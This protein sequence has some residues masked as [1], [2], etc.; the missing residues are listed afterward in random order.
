MDSAFG[1]RSHLIADIATEA[2]NL[3]IEIADIAG[4]V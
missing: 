4:H 3:G 2:G 1:G